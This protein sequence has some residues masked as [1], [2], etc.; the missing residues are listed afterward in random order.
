MNIKNKRNSANIALIVM[1]GAIGVSYYCYDSSSIEL[2]KVRKA[3]AKD[4]KEAHKN[5][6][7]AEDARA[8]LT[9]FEK[10]K[11]ISVAIL[12][13]KGKDNTLIGLFANDAEGE[14]AKKL[15]DGATQIGV[16]H[17]WSLASSN[18]TLGKLGY[19]GRVG[20]TGI[21]VSTN[22][23][24]TASM[25]QAVKFIGAVFNTGGFVQRITWSRSEALNGKAE[26]AIFI[27]TLPDDA[28]VDANISQVI[29]MVS[30]NSNLPII[31]LKEAAAGL[32]LGS[33]TDA[34]FT[35]ALEM[36]KTVEAKSSNTGEVA[37]G[38]G[39]FIRKNED[40]RLAKER[41][42]ALQKASK[43]V[44]QEYCKGLSESL[45]SQVGVFDN[46]NVIVAER[47]VACGAKLPAGVAA[48][49]KLPPGSYFMIE[50]G[51]PV[52]KCDV[53]LNNGYSESVSIPLERKSVDWGSILEGK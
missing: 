24:A 9:K 15:E 23:T 22:G 35:K 31:N 1:L 47:V 45:V 4:K 34:S 11:T 16:T 51:I 40:A 26:T 44:V 6:G 37:P 42:I 2:E 8:N 43:Q 5:D 17:S 25:T 52:L 41:S 19:T 39:D 18:F 3:I 10:A 49:L 32:N 38:D 27:P 12:G 46:E 36:V 21:P 48:K 53:A 7:E 14:I 20:V 50:N 28:I 29:S 13:E 30:P 33:M